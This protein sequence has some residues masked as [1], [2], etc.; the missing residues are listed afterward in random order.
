[1]IVHLKEEREERERLRKLQE[2]Q[3]SNRDSES[4]ILSVS[5]LALSFDTIR[6]GDTVSRSF[7]VKNTG[8]ALL[9]IQDISSNI[10]CLN[11]SPSIFLDKFDT[12]KYVDS[13]DSIRIEV[14]SQGLVTGDFAGKIDINSNAD[15]GVYSFPFDLVIVEK[16]LTLREKADFNGDGVVNTAD[17]LLF[18]DAFGDSDSQYDLDENGTVNVA[19]F[20]LFVNVFGS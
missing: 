18:L 4:P 5:P 7:Y 3:N 9:E 19:D 1:M 6:V 10:D 8:N 2:S 11:F 13:P 15:G 12:W 20:L 16:E 17:F 14:V